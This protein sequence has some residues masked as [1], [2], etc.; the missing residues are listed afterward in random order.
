MNP[1][2]D[3]ARWSNQVAK[4][5]NLLTKHV[6]GVEARMAHLERN[7]MAN[8]TD[9]TKF[10]DDFAA[11][12]TN[13]TNVITLLGYGGF[14][15]LWESTSERMAPFFFGLCGLLMAISLLLFVTWELAS[16]LV[17]AW[18]IRKARMP[19]E[20]GFRMGPAAAMALIGDSNDRLNRFHL[21]VFVP[22]VITGVVGGFMV[23]A[24]FLDHMIR[25]TMPS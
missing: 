9:P 3:L 17:T 5:V 10:L 19:D 8:N 4:Q 15:A 1:S 12:Q 16:M 6:S 2:D 23:L 20:N 13:Y 7:A 25:G 24:F 18:A 11:R 22:S 14:F 21:W